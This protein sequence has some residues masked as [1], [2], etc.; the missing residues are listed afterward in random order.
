[1]SGGRGGGGRDSDGIKGSALCTECCPC[2]CSH[3]E[4]VCLFV[5]GR[6]V[7]DTAALCRFICTGLFPCHSRTRY[8]HRTA[9]TNESPRGRS[10]PVRG[11]HS[12]VFFCG[13]PIEIETPNTTLHRGHVESTSRWTELKEPVRQSLRDKLQPWPPGTHLTSSCRVSLVSHQ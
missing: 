6:T 4:M 10:L 1:M 5:C 9:A 2:A 13:T 12:P 8:A 11:H 7:V 3:G